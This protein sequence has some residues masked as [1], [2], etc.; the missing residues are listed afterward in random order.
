MGSTKLDRIMS[1]VDDEIT[2]SALKAHDVS[3][4]WLPIPRQTVR[5]LLVDE[6]KQKAFL[7]AQDDILDCEVNFLTGD[8]M[9][10][11]LDTTHASIEDDEEVV[12][13]VKLLGEG[14]YGIVEAV[15]VTSNSTTI[16]CVRKRIGRPKQ[17]NA[18]KQLLAAFSREVKVMRQVRHPHCVQ[19]LGS[20]TEI[21]YV[22]ILSLPV[23]DT[24]LARFLDQ[25]VTQ[26]S[27]ETL[28]RG[29]GCLCNAINYLHDNNIRHEDLKPQNVLIHGDNILLTD[30]GFSLDFSED[31]VSTTTGRPSAWTIRYS[32]P[33]VLDFE[34]RNRATDIYSLG[35]VLLEMV[36]GIDGVTLSNLKTFWRTIGNGQSSFARNPE[37]VE[38]WFQGRQLY[39]LTGQDALRLKH[40]CRLI[41]LMLS[42]QRRHRPSAG[43]IVE[44]LCDISALV[45]APQSSLIASPCKEPKC[46]GLFNLEGTYSVVDQ[47]DQPVKF[48]MFLHPWRHEGQAGQEFWLLDMD[49]GMITSSRLTTIHFEDL[50]LVRIR[51]ACDEIYDQACRTGTT[52]DFW[53]AN[54]KQGKGG[55]SRDGKEDA[56]C[57]A[58]MVL[59]KHVVFIILLLEPHINANGE[60]SKDWIPLQVTLVPICLPKS[61]YY[62]SFFWML[63]WSADKVKP[64]DTPYNKLV[65]STRSI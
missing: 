52:K 29:I 45:P 1:I 59:A 46:L 11:A 64:T 5:R 47:L 14:A 55:I 33:E 28:S 60:Q 16:R 12:R 15:D 36:S 13:S 53:Q 62:G 24:D 39:D 19:F 57:S 9:L 17:L 54:Q 61:T 31:S 23:A 58:Q 26:Q 7:R 44:Y 27:R 25:P 6:R 43:H 50:D 2:W 20:Y 21:D 32:A 51:E 22:N 40:L 41:K 34:P 42:K 30:F 48:G 18:Q 4:I 63:S 65:D 10:S 38:A 35:C 56:W 3:D 8:A 37:A 49:W